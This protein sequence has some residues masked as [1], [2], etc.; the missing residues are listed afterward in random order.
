MEGNIQKILTSLIALYVSYEIRIAVEN[1]YASEN[2]MRQR[3]TSDSL[4]KIDELEEEKKL[5]EKKQIKNKNF[6]KVVENFVKIK[7]KED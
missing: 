6:K 2:I 4:K 3:I 5:Q 1:S 7:S